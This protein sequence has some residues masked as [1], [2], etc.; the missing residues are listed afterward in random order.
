MEAIRAG[1]FKQEIVPVTVPRRKGEPL[2]FDTDEHPRPDI[3]LEKLAKLPPAFKENGTVT[4]GNSSGLNDGACAAL[5]M[6]RK[7]ADELGLATMAR[8]KGYSVCGVDPDYMGIGPVPAIR[9]ILDGNQLT[10]GD[11]E[12]FEINEAFAAQYLACEIELDLNS[13]KV[14]LFGSGIAL[15]HPVGATGCRIMTTLLYGMIRD[16]Q[17]LGISSLCAGGGHGLRHFVGTSVK[18]CVSAARPG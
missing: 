4:A 10:V 1:A 17:T 13:D 8:I 15:G 7:R 9:K 11:I 6:S 2:I 16:N 14:N 5:I 3:T 12:R 18:Q